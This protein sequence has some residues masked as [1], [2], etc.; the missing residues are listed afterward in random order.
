M[1]T[2]AKQSGRSNS[3]QKQSIGSMIA[4]NL[5]QGTQQSIDRGIATITRIFDETKTYV[6][7]KP[8]EAALVG[9]AI[10]AAA[11]MLFATKPGR[12]VF[13]SA[14]ILFVPEMTKWLSRTFSAQA[15]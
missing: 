2:S 4:E 13:D 11:W 7:E 5:T 14:A 15:H 8:A 1:N 12:K 9:V 6:N 10:Q 3:T